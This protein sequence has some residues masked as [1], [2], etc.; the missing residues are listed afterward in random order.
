MIPISADAHVVGSAGAFIGL[1]ERFGADAPRVMF[2]G[3]LDDAVIIPA[4]SACFPWHTPSC[5]GVA[6]ADRARITRNNVI[7][8]Y[9]LQDRLALAGLTGG[10]IRR[11]A[12]A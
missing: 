11:G 9:G 8:L 4:N 2:A 10:E 7:E 12:D 5:P 3:T 6:A 1:A